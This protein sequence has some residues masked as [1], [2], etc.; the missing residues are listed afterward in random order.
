MRIAIGLAIAIGVAACSDGSAN[1][2]NQRP[3]V[4]LAFTADTNLPI[5]VKARP[6]HAV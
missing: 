2:H 5:V 4:P 6:T 3:F 1:G